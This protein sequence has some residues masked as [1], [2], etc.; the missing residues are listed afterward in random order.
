MSKYSR[1]K[2][3]DIPNSQ[4]KMTENKTRDI[5]FPSDTLH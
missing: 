3:I 1:V 4:N 2:L 5:F